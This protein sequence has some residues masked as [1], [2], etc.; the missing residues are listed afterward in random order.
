M[1]GCV[2]CGVA[3]F[4]LPTTVLSKSGKGGVGWSLCLS[5]NLKISRSKLKFFGIRLHT[6]DAC[7]QVGQALLH[8]GSG[9]SD[10]YA[11]QELSSGC[12]C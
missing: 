7:D 12:V 5:C 4:D 9:S 6:P 11:W 10:Y 2:V 1:A 8:C 3:G